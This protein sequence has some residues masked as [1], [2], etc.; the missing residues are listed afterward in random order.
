MATTQLKDLVE[1]KKKEVAGLEIIDTDT[2][3]DRP[4]FLIYGDSG[5]G[6]STLLA[7]ASEVEAMSP[8]FV[9][10]T[11]Y[12]W[13]SYRRRYTDWHGVHI[14]TIR[15]LEKV[16]K[17]I[18]KGE[19]DCNTVAIDNITELQQIGMQE[20]M[21]LDGKKDPDKTKNVGYVDPDA[22]EWTHYN[23]SKEQVIRIV[24]SFKEMGKF[25]VVTAWAAEDT[26]KDGN[27]VLTRPMLPSTT[28]KLTP[29]Y[30]DEVYYY[31]IKNNKRRILT[32]RTQKEVA[33]SR[34]GLEQ[35]IDDPT[36]TM[37]MEKMNNA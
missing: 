15:E 36:M 7:S 20:I 25:L 37:I 8:V 24:R 3:D 22:P 21:S 13:R 17:S 9:I 32:T 30:F 12:G 31:Y 18:A 23:K 33:K 4:S 26:D 5:V 35:V 19:L 11:E 14:R 27:V 34:A 2:A 1:Q 16:A 6:K 29:G 28:S 10:D